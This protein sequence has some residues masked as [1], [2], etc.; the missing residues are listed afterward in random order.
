[1][2]LIA[3]PQIFGLAFLNRGTGIWGIVRG[4]ERRCFEGRRK[5]LA[6]AGTNIF[7]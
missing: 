2:I 1:L 7:E 4:R 3:S 6:I 5:P